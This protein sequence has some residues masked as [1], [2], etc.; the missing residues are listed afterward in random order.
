MPDLRKGL[1]Q[2]LFSGSYIRRWNDKL[3]P[4]ELYEIDKQ[5]H[6]MMVAFLLI[7]VNSRSMNLE[8]RLELEQAVVERALFDYLYRLIVT[9]IKPP[10]FYRIKANREHY[11]QLTSWVLTELRPVVEPL[12]AGFWK[13]LE[14]YHWQPQ[15][16]ELAD[17]ILEAAHLFASGWEY[18]LIKDVNPSD[19]EQI[20]GSFAAGMSRIEGVQGLAELQAGDSTP[21]G[22]F[23]NL[24]GQLR[25][26]IRWS[27]TPRVPETSVLGHV[28]LVGTVAYMLSLVVGACPARR[29][30]NFFAGLFHD[31]PELLTRDIISPVKRAIHHLPELIREYELEELE[32][33]IFT[34][35]K[36]GGYTDIDDRLRYFLGMLGEATSEFDETVRDAGRVRVLTSFSEL[37]EHGNSNEL[38]PKDGVLLKA[39]DNLAAFL[40][41][42]VSVRNGVST[43]P[44]YEA[45][46]RI[47]NDFRKMQLGTFSLST[48]LADFD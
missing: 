32:R 7:A 21:L 6:K 19:E 45:I 25:F 31:L 20:E 1:L 39:C 30:N 27:G 22:R 41:A 33:R 18:G 16:H 37:H 12:D 3:R 38:D 24:C 2:L 10:V 4:M 28:F 42:H 15:R 17:R 26:Q 34:P 46:T 13:R 36:S 11:N 48:L 5:G 44:L 14:A 23:A 47:K 9:D 43:A 8:E 35:L 29:H 40:E